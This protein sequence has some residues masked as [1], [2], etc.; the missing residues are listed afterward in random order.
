MDKPNVFDLRADARKFPQRGP[1]ERVHY[2]P[3]DAVGSPATMPLCEAEREFRSDVEYVDEMRG[4]FGP[5][6]YK[7]F[8]HLGYN[9]CP[10]CS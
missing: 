9:V 5:D 3:G 4:M 10:K 1:L 6:K 8:P 2:C 7:H